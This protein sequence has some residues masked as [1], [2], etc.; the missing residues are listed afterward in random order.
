VGFTAYGSLWESEW[1][2]YVWVI[3]LSHVRK[4]EIIKN[5]SKI[6]FDKFFFVI[7]LFF[8]KRNFL[9]QKLESPILKTDF[10]RIGESSTFDFRSY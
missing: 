7:L 9:H 1:A 3:Y 6:I 4:S 8:F 5:I 10:V 2:W